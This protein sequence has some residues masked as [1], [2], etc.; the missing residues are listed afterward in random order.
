MNEETLNNLSREEA[1]K[2]LDSQMDYSYQLQHN[3]N[4]LKKCLEDYLKEKSKERLYDN[5]SYEAGVIATYENILDKMQELEKGG[6]N[7]C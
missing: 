4:E 2:L 3:W 7:D 5:N 1:I 6:N